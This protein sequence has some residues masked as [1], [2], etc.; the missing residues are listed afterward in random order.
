VRG[1]GASLELRCG[2]ARLCVVATP[3]VGS[4][5]LAGD[6]RAQ[7]SA[8]DRLKA[9]LGA[10]IGA[11]GVRGDGPEA[12]PSGAPVP[13][14]AKAIGTCEA[15][16]RAGSRARSCGAPRASSASA[17]VQRGRGIGCARDRRDR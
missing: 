14:A 7:A 1:T 6:G 5:P 17:A 10:R 3:P 4:A 13:P 9:V 15:P 16:A 8:C 11:T 2:G 12:V